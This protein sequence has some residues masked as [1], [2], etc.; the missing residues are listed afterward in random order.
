MNAVTT[1][2]ADPSFTPSLRLASPG[3]CS[4]TPGQSSHPRFEW[5]VERMTG[6]SLL[7]EVA[8]TAEAARPVFPMIVLGTIM[9]VTFVAIAFDW[10]H[11][12]VAALAGAL[13]AVA[14]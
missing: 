3:A 7:A 4:Y 9:T 13:A 14:A 2:R 11:K 12:S 1:T 8:A 6:W 10:V 5:D